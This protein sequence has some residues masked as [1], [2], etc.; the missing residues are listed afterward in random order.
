MKYFFEIVNRFM[1]SLRLEICVKHNKTNFVWIPRRGIVC[2][3]GVLDLDIE[4]G[5]GEPL[6]PN[7]WLCCQCVVGS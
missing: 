5:N 6:D 7:S 4:M 1:N 3:S 2:L